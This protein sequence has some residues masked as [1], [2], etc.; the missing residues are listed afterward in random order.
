MIGEHGLVQLRQ[1]DHRGMHRTPIQTPPLPIQHRADLVA[2]HHMRMQVRVPGTGIEVIK[3][4]RDQPRDV[5]LCNRAIPSSCTRAGGCHLALHERNHLMMG[6]RNQR[7]RPRVRNRPQHRRRLRHTE[8]EIKPR[9]RTPRP[10][11][12]LV[13]LD[14]HNRTTSLNQ[15]Q[16]RVQ[17]RDTIRN[18]IRC[19][20]VHR[21]R[22]PQRVT[23][24]RVPSHPDQQLKLSFRH[25]RT[26]GEF[27][28]PQSGHARTEPAPGWSASH[29][30]IASQRSRERPGH[31]HQPRPC[32]AGTCSRHRPTSPASTP[33]PKPPLTWSSHR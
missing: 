11:R 20:A 27:T 24:D 12:S 2:D 15:S 19:R 33:S 16:R 13:G 8:R 6:L 31:R 23:S 22:P 7:L 10:P 14:L 5:N 25:L 9:H 3:R 28:M 1:R 4:R 26:R 21:I 32:A 30:V 17:L 29:G 18:P